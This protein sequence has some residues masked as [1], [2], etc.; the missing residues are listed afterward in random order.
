MTLS[1]TYKKALGSQCNL[2]R[3]VQVEQLGYRDYNKLEADA[4]ANLKYDARKNTMD[5]GGTMKNPDRR[6][7][8]L[9]RFIKGY[10]TKTIGA[11]A[12]ADKKNK[13]GKI[14]GLDIPPPK[15]DWVWP[16]NPRDWAG[17]NKIDN[18]LTTK[19]IETL[20]EIYDVV[21]KSDPDAVAQAFEGPDFFVER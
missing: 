19:D 15:E 21:H 16:S 11:Y 3:W 2:T 20:G 18:L 14:I 5:L 1:T 9:R 6:L 13:D 17:D 12:E 7:A 10:S 4:S 8:P